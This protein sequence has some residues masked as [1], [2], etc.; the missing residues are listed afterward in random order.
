[1]TRRSLFAGLPRRIPRSVFV[2]AVIL[3]VTYAVFEAA[4]SV[5]YLKDVIEP[6]ASIWLYEGSGNTVHFDPIRGYRLTDVPSRMTRITRNTVEYVGVLRGNNEGFPDRDDFYPRRGPQGGKRIA[7]FGDS[8]TAAQFLGQ[9]WPDYV[10]DLAPD[11]PT[12]L[13]LLN[14][15]TDGGGLAN[16]WSV[17]TRIVEEDG[18]EID[19][20]IFA[21]IPG[22]L[23]RGFSVSDHRE[24]HHPLFGRVPEWNPE[25]FPRTLEEARTYLRPFTRDSHIV[26]AEEFD[27]ALDMQ[28]R[29]PSRKP[30][31]PYFTLKLWRALRGGLCLEKQGPTPPLAFGSFDPGQ[32]WMIRDMAR[33]IQTMDIP[34]MVVHVPSRESLVDGDRGAPPPVDTQLFAALL[35]ARVVDGKEAFLG[36]TEAEVRAMWFRYDAHWNQSGSNLFGRFMTTLLTDWPQ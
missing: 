23:W 8:Y 2:P 19:G 30:V 24:A 4:V 16:W 11:T 9:N 28:W 18:Y 22:N 1:M 14:F 10:E 5:L 17:L 31:R 33:A 35:G 27:R 29:P 21:V 15:S 7:V 26:S 32:E 12:A 34:A 25:A 20:V 3:V 13:H 36:S 6:P